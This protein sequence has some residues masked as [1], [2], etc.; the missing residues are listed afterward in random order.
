MVKCLTT[1]LAAH[2]RETDLCADVNEALAA[3]IATEATVDVRLLGIRQVCDLAHGAAVAGSAADDA[4]DGGKR[5]PPISVVSAELLR[6]VGNRVSSKNKTERKDAITGLAQVYY[7]HCL[8]PAVRDVQEGGD[9]A[10]IDTILDALRAAR[11]SGRETSPHDE[12]FAWIPRRVFEC[13]SFSDAVDS[14]MRGRVFQL[15]DDVLLGTARG[16]G[17]ALTPTSRAVGLALIVAGVKEKDNA[18]RWMQSLFVQRSRLQR[19]LGAYLDARARAKECPAGSP[20]AFA[21]DAAAVEKLEAVAALTAPVEGGGKSSPA[22][23][24]AAAVLK[25]VHTAKD[26]HVF[27]IL[28]TICDPA[29]SPAARARALDEL[30]KRTKG[31]GA[32]A[33]TWV[34]NLARRCAMGAFLNA[35]TV[36]HCILLARE[37]FEAGDCGAAAALLEC[38]RLAASV[39]PPLAGAGE[40]FKN[41]VEFFDAARTTS[42][43]AGMKREMEQYGVVTTLSEILA[44]SGAGAAAARPSAGTKADAADDGGS[45]DFDGNSGYDTLRAQLLR[46][47]TR[48]GTPAQARNGVRAISSLIGPAANL[49]GGAKA[50]AIKER[51]E[52]APLLKALV[53]PARLAIPDDD[54]SPKARGRIVSVLSALAAIAECAPYAFN[55]PREGNRTGWGHKALDF[56]LGTALLGKHARPNAS[57]TDD[58]D[59]GALED[60]S[61]AKKGRRSKGKGHGVSIHCQMLCG[62][63]EVLAGHIRA[64][65]LIGR[66]SALAKSHDGLPKLAPPSA[67][68][69]AAVFATL[70]Q[71]VEDGGVPPSGVDGRHGRTARD[72]AELRRSASVHL[73]RLCDASLK[74][75]ETHL[76]PRMWHVLSLALLDADKSVRG[77]FVDELS[78]LFTGA[79]AF[80]AVGLPPPAP[81]LRFVALVTLCADGDH[82]AHS[83]AN[84]LPAGAANVGHKKS[85]AAKAAATRCTK[86]L[87]AVCQSAAA[88]CRSAGRAAENNFEKRLKRKLMPEYIVPYA[89][90]LLAFRR[91]TASAAGTLAGEPDDA[92]SDVASEGDEEGGASGDVLHGQE[93]GQRMLKKR[94]KWLFDP[95]VQSLGASA[96]N[97]SLLCP[98]SL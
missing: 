43:T 33:Q 34:K 86:D 30:P 78:C 37:S 47:C 74:L 71:I 79:G 7:K 39:F 48:D 46:L 44:R 89:L 4:A 67:E 56:C 50:R 61:P 63:I 84:G 2:P 68:H 12:K 83:A 17:N 62:A 53:N 92:E 14:E 65:T 70:A 94:L 82:G 21:A 59:D 95:L 51:R 38:V 25:K 55:A 57:R 22:K 52:F 11:S 19:A 28:S 41:L 20:A 60:S 72:M 42:M 3:V 45:M 73:L 5:K 88:Q 23:A 93:A 36:G 85:H 54:A 49:P 9:D 80:R 8:K 16:G 64:T 58:D 87:R 6:A 35:E 24:D 1:F 13:A 81:S 66:Q 26:K 15:V 77:A 98:L 10:D 96:D 97:V 76:T 29:H 91:E 27:R 75:E 18:Y 31:L 69:I 90:H 40:G 32:P